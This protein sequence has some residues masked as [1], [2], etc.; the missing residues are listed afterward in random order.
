LVH[1]VDGIPKDQ[2]VVVQDYI[3]KVWGQSK[4]INSLKVSSH[5]DSL[6]ECEYYHVTPLC[7]YPPT[8]IKFILLRSQELPVA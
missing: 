8:L 6:W 5:G 1:S 3:D 4:P 7:S 2:C